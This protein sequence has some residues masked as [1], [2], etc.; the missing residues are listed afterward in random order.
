MLLLL[1]LLL[2]LPARHRFCSESCAHLAP[3]TYGHHSLAS[4]HHANKQVSKEAQQAIQT[5]TST[6]YR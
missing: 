4:Q 2:L 1:L 3:Y 5:R 6:Q